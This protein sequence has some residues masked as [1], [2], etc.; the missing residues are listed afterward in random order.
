[1]KTKLIL[2]QTSRF[3]KDALSRHNKHGL[4]ELANAADQRPSNNSAAWSS[5]TKGSLAL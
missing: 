1:M 5:N 4:E 3:G 2:E